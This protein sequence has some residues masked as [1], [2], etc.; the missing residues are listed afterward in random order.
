[1]FITAYTSSSETVSHFTASSPSE[2]FLTIPTSFAWMFT[3]NPSTDRSIQ[4]LHSLLYMTL[5]RHV[6]R[7]HDWT[8]VVTSIVC[9]C[10]RRTGKG[11]AYQL[12]YDGH[13]PAIEVYIYEHVLGRKDGPAFVCYD[14]AGRPR[15]EAYIRNA[16]IMLIRAFDEYGNEI[17]PDTGT[18]NR[19]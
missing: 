18:V 6:T 3:L 16:R 10:S 1:M 8:S 15:V 9:G 4:I 7:I 14:I 17:S 2:E 19:S 13:R 12:M 5:T 11:P